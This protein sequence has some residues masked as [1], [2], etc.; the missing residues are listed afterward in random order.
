MIEIENAPTRL[1]ALLIH[2]DTGKDR[3][4]NGFSRDEMVDEGAQLIESAGHIVSER[5]TGQ[6]ERADP[7]TFL[8]SGKVEE[9][10]A[11]ITAK[12]IK[13][14]VFNHRVTAIQARNLELAWGVRV[15]DRTE[16]ILDIF[17][18]R[19]QSH[20]GKLQVELA[21]LEHAATRLVRGWTHLERQRGGIG[22]RGGMGESQLEID[23]R[24]LTERVKATRE[25]L[26]KVERQRQ[27]QRARRHRGEQFRVVI[28]GYTNAGKSTLF[29][30]LTRA[31]TIA[32][33]QL[34]ATLD[35]TTRRLHL[36]EVG[37]IAISDTVG[38]IRDLPHTLVEAFKATLEEA[39]Q[40]DLLLHVF[41]A[42][43]PAHDD[44]IR[45]VDE[46]LRGIGAAE[47][48]QLLVAN[49]VDQCDPSREGAV[50]EGRDKI[51][52]VRVSAAT[53]LGLDD[54]RRAIAQLALERAPLNA[55]AAQRNLEEPPASLAIPPDP[56]TT[57]TPLSNVA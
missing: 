45:R 21:R 35:T 44:Q 31:K 30:R 6:R 24:L 42:S 17:A 19:A 52:A 33:D 26:R 16:L 54:L 47:V 2:V 56:F 37:T 23:R 4:Q 12:G 18:Q 39:V 10:A 20:E 27:T 15:I 57:G 38:F 25:R 34:F 5:F 1:H 43:N 49:K 32:A 55:P 13:L 3:R 14:V 48:P 7:G 51:T 40:A 28:V 11:L 36:P 46:V 53:G 29:N 9:M 22:L 41:D 50:E 8:G